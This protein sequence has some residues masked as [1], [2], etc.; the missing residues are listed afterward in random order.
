MTTNTPAT[1]QA[2]VSQTATRP[3]PVSELRACYRAMALT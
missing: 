1:Q 2:Q 3:L